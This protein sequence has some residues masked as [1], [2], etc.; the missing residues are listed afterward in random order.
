[1]STASA[2]APVAVIIGA[3]TGIG[4]GLVREA[5]RRGHRLAIAD[6]ADLADS[7]ADIR[8]RIDVRDAAGLEAFAQVVFERFGRVDLLFNNAGIMRPGRL[9]EQPR[10]HL[11]AL[12]DVNLGGVINGVRAFTPPMLASGLPG[13]IVNTA[14]LAG[15]ICAPGL[16]GYCISKHAVVALSEAL[17]IDFAH[18]GARLAVSVVCPGAVATNLMT[19]AKA[20]LSASGDGADAAFVARMEAGLAARGADP[21]RIA[22]IIFDEIARGTFCIIPTGETP[23]PLV[24]RAHDLMEGRT[25]SFSSWGAGGSSNGAV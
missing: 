16:A 6:Q 1:M 22:A 24:Q 5:R 4:A 21:D 19:A 18:A 2:T 20:A 3:A 25:P 15:L 8:T 17:A 7:G 13:R 14:S 23:T 10:A 11:D 12:L 9:W